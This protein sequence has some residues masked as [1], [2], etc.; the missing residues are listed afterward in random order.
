MSG[1]TEAPQP[2][3]KGI[4]SGVSKEHVG[5]PGREGFSLSLPEWLVNLD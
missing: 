4:H 2:R 3:A 5:S 1:I